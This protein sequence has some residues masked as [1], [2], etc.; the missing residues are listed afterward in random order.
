MYCGVTQALK[1]APALV[2]AA[3]VPLSSNAWAA[4]DKPAYP[5]SAIPETEKFSR[6]DKLSS[7]ET[8]N[9]ADRKKIL[10][11]LYDRLRKAED[12]PTAAIVAQAIEKLWLHSGSAT[13]DILMNRAGVLMRDEDHEVALEILNSIIKIAPAYA[14]GWSRRAALHF[15]KRDFANSLDD[16]RHALALD[17]SHF[18]AI[19]GLALLMQELGDKKAALKAFRHALKVHPHLE[20]LRRSEQELARE[21]EGQGI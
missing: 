10:T 11:E 7:I 14:E 13:I 19:Q 17:P 16:L 21:V 2:C 6:E 8:D 12:E 1:R 20:D 18:K 15:V 4:P 5:H 9:V 3:I